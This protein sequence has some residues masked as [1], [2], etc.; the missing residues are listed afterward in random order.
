MVLGMEVVY[1][2]MLYYSNVLKVPIVGRRCWKIARIMI[3]VEVSN[4]KREENSR[5]PV[6]LFDFLNSLIRNSCSSIAFRF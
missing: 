4:N 5:T 2:F 6:L 3:N 1:E